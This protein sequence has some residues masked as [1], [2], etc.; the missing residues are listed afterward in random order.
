MQT[1]Q[2]CVSMYPQ[3]RTLFH[4]SVLITV[5]IYNFNSHIANWPS[6]MFIISLSSKQVKKA[7]HFQDTVCQL[8]C[9]KKVHQYDLECV[10]LFYDT[11][12]ALGL[13]WIKD[14]ITPVVHKN[15]I[16]Y[17]SLSCEST[18]DILVFPPPALTPTN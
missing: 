7:S 10:Y 17:T 8:F 2:H 14:R 5:N 13:D 16:W 9:F 11:P 18:V 1:R 12:T 3:Y 15:L 6:S 4:I